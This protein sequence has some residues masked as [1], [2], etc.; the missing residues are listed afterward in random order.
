[1]EKES[2]QCVIKTL[3]IS[4]YNVSTLFQTGK[5]HQ[6]F[7]GCAD[8]G[9]DMIGIQEHWLFTTNP[10]EELCL[11]TGTGCLFMDLPLI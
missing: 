7:T 4:T 5:L 8:A 2:I 9:I 1:M 10:T 11:R 3:V 6:L